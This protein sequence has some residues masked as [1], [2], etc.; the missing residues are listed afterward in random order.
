MRTTSTE[1]GG[2]NQNRV[3]EVHGSALTIGQATLIEHLQE[4]IEHVRV[5]LL[6]LVEKHDGVR[7]ATNSLGELTASVVADVSGRSTNQTSD[8]VLLAVLGHIDAHHRTL[9][10]E[11]ELRQRLGQLCLTN[12]S[13]TEEQEGT[14]RTVR[15]GNTR[16][17]TA[18]GIGDSL[19]SGI[20]TNNATAEVEL[21][22]EQLLGL[23]LHHL[24]SRDTRPG[25]DNLSDFLRR[26]LLLEH[27]VFLCVSDRF[28]GGL[29]L[30]LQLRDASVTQL[31]DAPVVTFALSLFGL[32]AQGIEL[33]ADGADIIN[34]GLLVLPASLQSVELLALICKFLTELVQTLLRRDVSFLL[35]GHFLDFEAAH[36]AFRGVDFLRRGVNLHTQT[37]CGLINQVDSLIRQEAG[38]D[39]AIRQR[40]CSH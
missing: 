37:R 33:F 35:Q 12:A 3:S 32:S 17:R 6:D 18:D 24:A 40:C 8:R 15:I 11:E 1:V 2:Q 25:G 21:H 31:C 36:D 39:V 7:T 23:T 10:V 26:D 13:W 19:H 29:Q 38:C 5:S 27:G 20:L 22:F 14:S 30:L 9:I 28:L 34:R 4:H 16:T